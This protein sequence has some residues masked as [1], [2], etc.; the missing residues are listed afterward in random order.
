ML[1]YQ[2]IGGG[3]GVG[4][5]LGKLP[6]NLLAKIKYGDVYGEAS[7]TDLQVNE[8]LAALVTNLNL[9]AA[10]FKLQPVLAT[11]VISP[12]AAQLAINI[13]NRMQAEGL[14]LASTSTPT[15]VEE[16]VGM[17][18]HI[19]APGLDEKAVIRYMAENADKLNSAFLAVA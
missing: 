14:V 5:G 10:A 12:T 9:A 6:D 4:N 17:L 16:Y 1:T 3:N 8:I 11:G 15:E 13:A 2:H 7:S 19:R 18:L